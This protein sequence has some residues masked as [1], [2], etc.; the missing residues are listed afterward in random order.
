M[1]FTI[2][3]PCS[4]QLIFKRKDQEGVGRQQ[5]QLVGCHGAGE[6]C[7]LQRQMEIGLHQD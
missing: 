6:R 5:P 1:C 3:G 2:D 4:I 7:L